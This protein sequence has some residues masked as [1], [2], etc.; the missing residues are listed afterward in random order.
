MQQN[1]RVTK[2]NTPDK[3]ETLVR[4]KEEALSLI[5]GLEQKLSHKLSNPDRATY[6]CAR[7]TL[8]E[9][10]G[11][12]KMLPAAREAFAFC[13]NANSA[14][15]VAVALHHNGQ[16]KEANEWYERAYKYPH[17]A[18][19]EID[20]GYTNA[21][22]CTG[23]WTKAWPIIRKLKKR[24]VYA[25][26]LPEWNGQSIPELQVISEG[27][28]GDIIQ[29]TRFLPL[30]ASRGVQ[31][32][33]V[34]LPP[35]F[36]D[37]GFVKL[38]ES[39]NW[40]NFHIRPL[41]EAR[42]NIPSV[43]FFDLPA[44]FSTTYETL[45]PAPIWK[46][47]KNFGLS[48]NNFHVGLCWAAKAFET[49]LCPEGVYRSLTREQAT[50]ILETKNESLHYFSLQK[51]DSLPGLPQAELNSWTTTAELINSLDAVITVDTAVM[52]LAA[53]MGKPIYLLL[54]GASDWKFSIDDEY[55]RWYPNVRIF[56]SNEFGF[57][58]AVD[59]LIT[60]ISGDLFLEEITDKMNA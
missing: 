5:A 49:P 10:L 19:F 13:K 1:Y 14:A 21:L 48:C 17:E 29:N 52:H 31:K 50:R 27:G 34:Y 8:Y 33:T 57:E 41:T 24:M 23:N 22:L 30:L 3:D 2:W 46:T 53:S 32:V 4:S 12:P 59:K 42:Q 45:P 40:C 58:K 25:A 43:G 47:D 18:G 38:L 51:E 28:Y 20:I 7:A 44:V 15:L 9:A 37:S 56:R 54:S 11:D 35:M 55:C 60:V 26:Y 16:L 36:F 39:Q 6:L